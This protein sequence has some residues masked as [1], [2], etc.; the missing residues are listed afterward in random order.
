MK[1]RPATLDQLIAHLVAHR[2]QYP[3]HSDWPVEMRSHLLAVLPKHCAHDD[4]EQVVLLAGI[5]V[6]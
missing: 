5:Q 6:R 2:E 3:H 4:Q 1:P